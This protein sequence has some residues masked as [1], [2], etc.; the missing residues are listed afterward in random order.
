MN[1]Q[2]P[3]FYFFSESSILLQWDC[4]PDRKLLKHLLSVK[5]ALQKNLKAEITHTYNEILLRFEEKISD[6][7]SCVEQITAEMKET[8]PL[9]VTNQKVHHLPVCYDRKFGLDLQLICKTNELEEQELISLHTAPDYLVFF[10]GFLP[11]FPYLQGLNK[12]LHMDRKKVPRKRIPKGS[13]GIAG[14]QT[15]I[16]PKASPAGW[17]LIGNCP[18]PLFNVRNNPPT[19]FSSGDSIRFFPINFKEYG[20]ISE[21]SAKGKYAFKSSEYER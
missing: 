8:K 21:L 10:I 2:T 17:Q 6:F 12:K 14:S 5:I 13:V 20:R 7:D 3:Q 11:G 4:A 1:F 9:G 19:V 16:Y 18:V 15:G